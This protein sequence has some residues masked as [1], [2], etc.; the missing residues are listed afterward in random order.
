M[1]KG[2]FKGFLY[3]LICGV[4]ITVGTGMGW[5]KRSPIL[6]GL[7]IDHFKATVHIPTDNPFGAGKDNVTLLVLGCDEDW[8][9][10][11]KQLIR[12]QARS[13]MMLLCKIDFKNK[14][15][16]GVSIPRDTLVA[17]DGRHDQKIN[18]Y[19]LYGHT[20]EEKA[21]SSKRAVETLLP[22]VHI[23]KVL[24]L[25]FD[26]FK[27]MVD[28]VGG[29]DMFVPKNMNYDDNRGHLHIHLKAGHQHLDGDQSEGFVRF[30]HS[31]DDFHRA[32]RQHDFVLAFKDA[33][34][35][36]WT[37]LPEV[38]EKARGLTGN[39]LSDDQIA[40]IANFAENIGSDN[41]SMGLIPTV[42]AHD[43]EYDLKLDESKVDDVLAQ[44]HFIDNNASTSTSTK[45]G[46]SAKN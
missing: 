15:I 24:V 20:D 14:Y 3:L 23:D 9:Y 32:S 42:D 2:I 37:E 44:Y 33:V 21:E 8:Y 38:V 29:V 13:D 19:H 31:D 43:D 25:N 6:R 12:H 10:G 26:S 17:S 46:S 27:E 45:D 16:S 22:D 18:A 4:A 34:R 1:W 28:V 11:G 40:Y 5:I 36:H 35:Q 7:L 41:I 30:R 39:A